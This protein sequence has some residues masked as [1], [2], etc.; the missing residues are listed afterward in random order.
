M[1]WELHQRPPATVCP[2]EFCFHWV[3]A[4]GRASPPGREYASRAEMFRDAANWPVWPEGGCGCGFGVCRR[5]RPGEAATDWYEPHE[6]RLEAAGLP[7]FYFTT[8]A[9]LRA[10]FHQK[11][12]QEAT[13][14]WGPEAVAEPKIEEI[15]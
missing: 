7:W 8:L 15:G 6:P 12:V 11:F 1:K 4:G 13:Q 3:S 2:E 9:A 5:A 10:D 14:L